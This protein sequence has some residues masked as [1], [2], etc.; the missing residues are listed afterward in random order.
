MINEL[1]KKE[2]EKFP[3]W[4]PNIIVSTTPRGMKLTVPKEQVLCS[5]EEIFKF[6]QTIAKEV[7]MRFNEINFTFTNTNIEELRN[8]ELI[9]NLAN[10]IINEVF[11]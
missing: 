4:S 2:I 6:G 8:L 9:G 10:Q 5:K 7:A 11:E 1:I 3:V